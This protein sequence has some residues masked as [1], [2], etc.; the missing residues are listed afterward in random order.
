MRFTAVAIALAMALAQASDP[1]EQALQSFDPTQRHALGLAGSFLK[2][3]GITAPWM[4]YS[5][6]HVRQLQESKVVLPADCKAKCPNLEAG[7]KGL[8]KKMSDAMMPHFSAIQ[9]VQQDMAGGGDPTP[10]QVTAMMKQFMPVFKDILTATFEDMCTNKANYLCM[11]TNA[12]VCTPAGQQ[13]SMGMSMDDPMSMSKDYGPMLGCMCDKCPSS[14]AVFIEST[15]TMMSVM[16]SAMMQMAAAMQSGKKMDNSSAMDPQMQ[17]DVMGAV[18]PM[19]GVQRCFDAYPTDCNVMKEKA[20]GS[21]SSVD[22]NKAMDGIAAMETECQKF[23]ATTKAAALEKVS[24]VLTMKGLDYTKVMANDKVKTLLVAKIKEQ[25][26]KKMP[27]YIAGDLEVTLSKGSVK[28]TVAITPM[29]GSS[30]DILKAAVVANKDV[31]T[32]SVLTEVKTMPANDMNAVLESGKT[33]ADLTA[34]AAAPTAAASPSG[35]TTSATSVAGSYAAGVA[36]PLVAV[37]AW[38]MMSSMM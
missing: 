36:G 5:Q 30:T 19:I 24:T 10:Q 11:M 38:A 12:E 9:K 14:R 26:L 37:L 29:P 33:A 3:Q 23:G 2:R 13:P 1:M 31:V 7:L 15:M 18:C 28:A 17:K 20:L 34:T 21:I 6:G 35:T 16:M 27:G 32:A 22:K 4:K 8:E 25:F